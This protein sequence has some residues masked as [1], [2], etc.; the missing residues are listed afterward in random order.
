M[1]YDHDE[2]VDRLAKKFKTKHRREGVD[3]IS[4]NRA[5]EVATSPED[6]R[7]SVPQLNRSRAAKKY[8]VVPPSL[9]KE[10][11]KLLKDTGIGMMNTRGAI[12]KRSRKKKQ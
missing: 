10:A 11:E 1:S 5:M 4:K 9:Y 12:K 8:M 6:L 3:I 2:I 7:Q